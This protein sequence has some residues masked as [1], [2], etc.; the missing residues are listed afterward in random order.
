MKPNWELNNCCN[1]EQ[2][3]FLVTVGVCTV[4]ILAVCTPLLSHLSFPLC[5]GST[6]HTQ[7]LVRPKLGTLFLLG[8]IFS[9][10]VLLLKQNQM[11]FCK[12]VYSGAAFLN[13]N[14][15]FQSQRFKL[16]RNVLF[17]YYRKLLQLSIIKIGYG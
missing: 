11:P 9:D 10:I 7:L 13:L 5:I 1:H 12:W 6:K 4:V 17:P 16:T 8:K 15:Y 14:C 2:V 3:V